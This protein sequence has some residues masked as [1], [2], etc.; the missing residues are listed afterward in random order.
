MRMTLLSEKSEIP[1]FEIWK[2]YF[3]NVEEELLTCLLSLYV[4]VFL[5]SEVSWHHISV[6]RNRILKMIQGT[7]ASKETGLFCYAV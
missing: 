1:Q 3:N 5:L 6:R 7:I 2:Q 4:S